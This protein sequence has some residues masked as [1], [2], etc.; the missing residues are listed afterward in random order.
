MVACNAASISTM[1]KKDYEDNL[2]GIADKEKIM[3][4]LSNKLKSYC[5]AV[6]KGLKTVK[7]KEDF[8]GKFWI[9]N[10]RGIGTTMPV[11]ASD[12]GLDKEHKLWRTFASEGFK[13]N[14]DEE[15]AG[16]LKQMTPVLKSI[17]GKLK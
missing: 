7:T 2:K 10:I 13:P 6:A 1:I 14:S 17:I 8:N 12:L 3:A 4:G 16:K 9:E 15:V 5:V 11:L